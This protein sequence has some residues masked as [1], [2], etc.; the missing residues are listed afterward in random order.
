MN[1]LPPPD[2]LV[3]AFIP[4]YNNGGV[5]PVIA[6]YIPKFSKE[7][8][9]FDDFYIEDYDEEADT[10]YW[11]EG[12]YEHVANWDDLTH[13]KMADPVYWCEIDYTS[14]KTL[15]SRG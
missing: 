8:N 12:W 5:T 14:A 3:L 1:L 10:Y 13:I 4:Y 9:E 2:K 6:S 7:V 11:P 15:S